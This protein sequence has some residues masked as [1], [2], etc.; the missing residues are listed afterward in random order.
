MAVGRRCANDAKMGS[1]RGC[2]DGR[3]PVLGQIRR[4]FFGATP[5]RE[6]FRLDRRERR[7]SVQFYPPILC[8]FTPPLTDLFP[9]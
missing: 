6:P 3:S 1:A 7:P 9:M 2:T 5:I 4:P 8:N